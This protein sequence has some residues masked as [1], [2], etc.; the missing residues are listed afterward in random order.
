MRAQAGP[1]SRPLAIANGRASRHAAPTARRR[2]GGGAAPTVPACSG[3]SRTAVAALS[4]NTPVNCAWKPEM[5]L[6]P[7]RRVNDMATIV[8]PTSQPIAQSDARPPQQHDPDPGLHRLE[9]EGCR[10]RDA[11]AAAVE[12]VEQE[13]RA[14]QQ[15]AVL[16]VP[17]DQGLDRGGP[18]VEHLAQAGPRRPAVGDGQRRVV[19]Q[20]EGE[21]VPDHDGRGDGGGRAEDPPQRAARPATRVRPRPDGALAVDGPR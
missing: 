2:H 18:P 19:L 8:P 14:R 5:K 21:R 10:G 20:H 3:N 12:E 9:G 4:A 6:S 11:V 13:Q 16:V 1:A 15:D 7:W 17:G